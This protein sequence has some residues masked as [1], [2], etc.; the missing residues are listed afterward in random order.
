MYITSGWMGHVLSNRLSA[1]NMAFWTLLYKSGALC[2]HLSS[3]P[4]ARE[5]SEGD[6]GWVGKEPAPSCILTDPWEC[7]PV[8]VYHSGSGD[9]FQ[10][11]ALC[12]T[13]P[14]LAEAQLCRSLSSCD[15][16]STSEAAT[17]SPQG[18]FF[19]LVGSNSSNLYPLLSQFLGW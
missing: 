16:S 7:Y 14:I 8:I 19:K 1:P 9:W 6:W 12:C 13:F 10:C 2:N 4:S 18:S 5:M 17:P 11:S 15:D 3:L